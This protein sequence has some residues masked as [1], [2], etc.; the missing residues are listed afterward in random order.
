MNKN[1]KDIMIS[2]DDEINDIKEYISRIDKFDKMYSYLTNYVLIK[3]CGTLE[4]VYKSIIVNYF[5]NCNLDAAK[6]FINNKITN[7]S[8]SIRY[9]VLCSVLKQFGNSWHD[10]FVNMLTSLPNNQQLILSTQSLT[11]NRHMFAH[12]KNPTA[13][14]DEIID[15]YTDCKK[16]ISILDSSII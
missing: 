4:L 9:D 6:S 14:F 16:V 12:G 15:Y 11:N 7:S 2:C 10:S 3:S 1:L 8:S 13:S 5:D